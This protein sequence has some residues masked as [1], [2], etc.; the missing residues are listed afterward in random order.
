MIGIEIH[1][2]NSVMDTFSVSQNV[3]IPEDILIPEVWWNRLRDKLELDETVK[4]FGSPTESGYRRFLSAMM[5][6]RAIMFLFFGLVG[7]TVMARANLRGE[8]FPV[9]IVIG[10]SAMTLTGIWWAVWPLRANRWADR[11][12]YIITDW[13]V[14]IFGSFPSGSEMICSIPDILSVKIMRKKNNRGDIHVQFED[15]RSQ[16]DFH[17]SPDRVAF[18]VDV[19][20]P[21]M[22]VSLLKTGGDE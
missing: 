21:D 6:P 20:N 3:K 5:V 14:I 12:A 9:I 16:G 10:L 22:L 13:H 15:A 1:V 18:L 17:E 19:E 2:K 11:T 7:F 8:T 4:W